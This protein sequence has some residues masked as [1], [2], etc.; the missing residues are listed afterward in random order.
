MKTRILSVLTVVAAGLLCA[1]QAQKPSF[2]EVKDGKFVCEDYPSH[3]VG[4][5]FWYG[6]ILGSEG[7]GGDRARLEAELDTLKALGMTNLRVLVGGDGPDGIPTRVSPTLQKEPG[8][9]NDTIF[10]GLDYLLAE[11]GERNMK[12]VL[13]INNSWEWSG[14][15]GM[16][17]E[18]A[19]EGK[20]LI[21]AEVGYSAFM[22]SVSKFV[23]NEKAKEMFYD[24]VRH[25]VS[26]T[27]TVTGKPYKDD[28]A[29]FSWQIGNEPRCFRADKEGQDAFV[30]YMWTTAALIK[31][32]DPN[33][34][35]S[36]GSEGEMGCENSME[37]YE[38]IHSCPDIDYMNIHIWPYNWNWVRENTL[39]TN[40]P[41]AIKNTDDYIDAHLALAAKYGKPVV[42]EEFG[43][44]RDGFQFKQ[45]TSTDSR[46]AYYKHVFGRIVESAREGGLFAGL[47]FWGWG[48]LAGQS[49][50]NIYWQPGDDYCGDPAQEQ[51]G[52][53]SVYAS[54]VS[55]TA[56]IKESSEAIERALLPK[57]RFVLEE[58]SGIFTGKGPH[59]VE[60]ELTSSA[61]KKAELLLE[62]STDFGCPVTTAS[63]T[64]KFQEGKA[65]T[66]FGLNL[67]P[68]FYAAVLSLVNEDGSKVEIDRTNLGFNPEQIVSDQDKQPDFDTFWEQ[69][70]AE[71][72]AVAPD[73]KFTLLED[74]SNDVRKSY[75]VDMKSFGG[76]QVSGL[77]LLPTAEGK[78]PA[79]IS[80]MGYGSDV[81]YADPSSNPDRIEFMLCIRNQAF[82]RAPGEKD[83]WCTRGLGDEYAYYYRGAFAD[84]VRAIDFVCSLPQTDTERV[85][86]YGE[87]Q[88]GALTLVAA[89]LD[90][91]L[92]AIA[93]SAPFLN[94]YKDY[95][96]LADWPGNWYIQAAK[97]RGIS[98]EDLYRCLSYFDVK[99]F[100]DRI[101]CPVLMAIGLQ[102]TVCPPHTN[103][104]GYNQIKTEKSWIC[105]P[106]AGHNV[107]QQEGWSVAREDFL[108]KYL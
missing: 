12:A 96:V 83:D 45:G 11:M 59:T 7:V 33:H 46:D 97:E 17:L 104:A 27:N 29:I 36:S 6:A 51:Q 31:S 61:A 77:L 57:A 102:D 107:W 88:G 18:W 92:K 67:E 68:G 14:G 72:A 81:W 70:L 35:V 20:A 9:Y 13:Y 63:K 5:N 106:A 30:D 74:H 40:L 23:T 76:E 38:R 71:L 22:N 86:A 32:I 78:Y 75:R 62:I 79:V 95:F 16:Y 73:Y 60:V 93:P 58:N 1:C 25:V 44:P 19:G 37:L 91:R 3:Y 21:P 54:D 26:R 8:V 52:L 50:T 66:S 2:V 94:D 49:E 82:N 24:H 85:V 89:S 64:V 69:T 47:N 80:Y 48:G 105:Y 90:H 56:I 53:N 84:A 108:K 43:F 101:Q 4:T 34:M 87:S 55:T 65:V 103:F 39:V 99:N 41:V 100:T 28:P 98:D 42:L 10:W 15:Y